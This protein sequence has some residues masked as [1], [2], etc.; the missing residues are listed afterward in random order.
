MKTNPKTQ[1]HE[2]ALYVPNLT[3]LVSGKTGGQNIILDD[4]YLLHRIMYVLRLGI[5]QVLILF[6]QKIHVQAKIHDIVRKK[7]I[8][9]YI[10]EINQNIVYKPNIS[11][12]LP[13]LKKDAFETAL[14]SL[15][16]V[17]I[18]QI[19]LIATKKGQTLTPKEY[20]R[21]KKIIIAAAE[22]S[23]NFAFPDLLP[24]I[25]LIT[26]IKQLKKKSLCLF[27]D[28]IGILLQEYLRQNNITYNDSIIL[29][30]GSE[31]D[32]TQSEKDLLKNAGFIFCALT[33][34]MLRASS[35]AALSAGLIRS[36]LR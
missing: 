5:E 30:I 34:T 7:A 8:H 21:A 16:E 31:G 20:E 23:K 25:D 22:Q 6:D 33:P 35:A 11:F 13:V 4:I 10:E 9:C 36:L 32:L 2:F 12:W 14:Y 19:Q 15:S 18:S 26:G 28:P 17:G 24:S 27:F 3:Q 29:A 1:K